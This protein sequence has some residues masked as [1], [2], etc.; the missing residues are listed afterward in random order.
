MGYMKY[1][2]HPSKL[3]LHGGVREIT[4]SKQKPISPFGVGRVVLI[5]YCDT[6]IISTTL[7]RRVTTTADARG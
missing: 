2:R 5:V 1:N 3:V 7:F 6:R 4:G